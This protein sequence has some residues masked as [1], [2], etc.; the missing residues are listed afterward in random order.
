MWLFALD[1]LL[2]TIGM[3][4]A[5]ILA[6]SSRTLSRKWAALS[7]LNALLALVGFCLAVARVIPHAWATFSSAAEWTNMLLDG[8]GVPLWALWLGRQLRVLSAEA[9]AY[10]ASHDAMASVESARRSQSSIGNEYGAEAASPAACGGVAA[11]AA[12]G[13]RLPAEFITADMNFS[14][15]NFSDSGSGRGTE[16]SRRELEEQGVV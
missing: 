11:T 15:P 6:L 10:Q 4:N 12:G 9:G 7:G 2:L 16:M 5:A 14:G 13:D 3:V 8:L 1:D